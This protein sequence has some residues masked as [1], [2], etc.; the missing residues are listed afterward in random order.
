MFDAGSPH[1]ALRKSNNTSAPSHGYPGSP[2][3][4]PVRLPPSK[5]KGQG[6][7]A[8]APRHP[9]QYHL[10]S[11]SPGSLF[12]ITLPLVLAAKKRSSHAHA[13]MLKFG[14]V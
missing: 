7:S 8:H 10:P 12:L 4:A 13:N 6:N 2:A 9:N 3:P 14:Y 1:P 5:G 11:Y